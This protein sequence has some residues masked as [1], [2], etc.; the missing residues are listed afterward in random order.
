[1]KKANT[2]KKNYKIKP[3]IRWAGGKNWLTK[4]IEN[5]IPKDF[6]NYHE[7]F[8]GGASIYI[9]LKSKGL[10]K[11]N[12]YLSDLNQELILTYKIIQNDPDSIIN[13]LNK[14]KNTK[15][16]YYKIRKSKPKNDIEIASRFLYLNKTS[17][18]GLY[19]VNKK[20]EYNVPYGYRKSN[21]LFDFINIKRLSLLLNDKKTYIFNTS[22]EETIKNI[23]K[24]DL[25]FLDPPYTVAHGNNGFIEYNELIFTWQHQIKLADLIEKINKIGAYYIMTNAAHSSILKLFSGLGKKYD[26]E[27]FSSIGGKNAKRQKIKEYIFTN[28]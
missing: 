18:N 28:V 13:I 15:D 5:F 8:I 2:I 9:Y 23:K 26:L 6:N 16:F 1:M 25:V 3:I 4:Y 17:F 20:G 22:F 11:Q 21:N 12:S 7:P 24:R 10:I 27:R 14:L 19:R